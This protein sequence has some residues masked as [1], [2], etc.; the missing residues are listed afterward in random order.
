MSMVYIELPDMNLGP[1]DVPLIGEVNM[2]LTDLA[3]SRVS[4]A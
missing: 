1:F 2:N 4:I 3:C